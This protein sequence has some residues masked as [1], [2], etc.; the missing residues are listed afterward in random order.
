[1]PIGVLVTNLNYF[2]GERLARIT[3]T[4]NPL[5]G[6]DEALFTNG[7]LRKRVLSRQA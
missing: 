3:I 1:M 4:W 2:N 6:I 5:E 7:I